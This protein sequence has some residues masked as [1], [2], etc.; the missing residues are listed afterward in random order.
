MHTVLDTSTEPPIQ[1][2]HP[3][4]AWIH[5]HDDSWLFT[6]A[7]VGLAVVLSIWISLFWLVVIVGL[8]GV[9]EWIRQRAL[10]RGMAAVVWEIKLDLS[11]VLLA[12][13]LAAYM[14]VVLGA[15]G[16]GGAA[17]L[18]AQAAVRATGWS[19]A[20]RGVL[21]S[22]DDAAQVARMVAARNGGATAADVE[23]IRA[24]WR[25]GDHIGVWLGVASVVLL[26][27]A[28]SLT[29]QPPGDLAQSLLAELHPWPTQG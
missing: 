20:L 27:L 26:L 1:P 13:V 4:R 24:R 2:L 17:R 10:G 28:P 23:E 7:Y 11:L 29:G 8:H 18:G 5:N 6:I 16:L 19:R 22:L 21:L 14:D 9:L 25:V 12:L 3:L 15:A